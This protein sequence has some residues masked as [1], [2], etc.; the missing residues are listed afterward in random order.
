MSYAVF[1]FKTDGTIVHGT[2][3][4]AP[5]G[6]QIHEAIGGYM[7]TVPYFKRYGNYQRGIAYTDEEGRLK[8]KPVNETASKLWWQNLECYGKPYR[9]YPLVGDVIYYCKMPKED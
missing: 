9:K 1:V 2:Q 3:P 6:D 7:E 5:D 4:K 8:R